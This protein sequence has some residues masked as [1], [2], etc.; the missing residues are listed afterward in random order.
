V[1]ITRVNS[2]VDAVN[3]HVE[4]VDSQVGR[5]NLLI[6]VAS[7]AGAVGVVAIAFAAYF[8]V[9]HEA[10]AQ[11][12]EQTDAGVIPLQ[13][14]VSTV[15]QQV[16]QLRDEVYE[17]RKDTQALYKAVVDRKRQDRLEK[18]IPPPEPPKQDGGP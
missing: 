11:A 7:G 4:A 13:N 12:K 6:K 2:R 1:K 3:E 16:S 18:P 8:A 17:G 10:K 14:R 5:L 15:E 9:I